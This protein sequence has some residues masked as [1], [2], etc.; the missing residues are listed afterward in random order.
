MFVPVVAGLLVVLALGAGV[1]LALVR[2]ASAR[3]E[4]LESACVA[5]LGG[6]DRG[7]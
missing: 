1:L 6:A 3:S 5:S 2:R 7:R 4:Y